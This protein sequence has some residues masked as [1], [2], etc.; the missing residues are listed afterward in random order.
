MI[1][2]E[3]CFDLAIIDVDSILYQIAYTT[4]SPALCKKH[5]DEAIDNIM[6]KTGAADGLV[7]MKGKDN[8][9][10]QVDPEYKGTRKDTIEPEVRER[11]EMLY[12]YAKDFCIAS[13]GAEADDLCGVYAR[14][15]LDNGETYIICHIDKDLNGLTG[16][17]YNFRSHKL[18]YVSD[19]EAYRFLMMQVLTGDST[20]NIQGLRGIGEKTAIKLT[21]DTP[22]TR[23]WDRVIEIWKDKQPETWYNNFVKCANC[24][25]IREFNDDLRPLSFEELKERL[26]WTETT[27]TGTLSQTDQLTPSD[28]STPLSTSKQEEDTSAESSS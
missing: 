12:E 14:T 11:I 6:E 10:Y 1:E 22:N 27:D 19:S 26:T 23:L 16:W 7:F 15:A 13:H 28:S 2:Q 25:Y 24:I 17:H 9:R 5:L 21:K 3:D 8:F 18:Y 4:P 20:D